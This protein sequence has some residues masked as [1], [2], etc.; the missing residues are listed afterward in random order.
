MSIDERMGKQMWY[1]HTIEFV[2]PYKREEILT[3]GPMQMNLED[4]LSE[5]NQKQKDKYYIIPLTGDN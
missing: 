4:I 1:I 3:Y 5:I 2:Q